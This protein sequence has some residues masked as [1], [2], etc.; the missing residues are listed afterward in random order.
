MAVDIDFNMKGAEAVASKAN[1]LARSMG[2]LE[3]SWSKYNRAVSKGSI[4][5][6]L[7]S[8]VAKSA[9]GASGAS[10]IGS[11]VAFMTVQKVIEKL[12]GDAMK[13]WAASQVKD[14]MLRWGK[15]LRS[16]SF[17]LDRVV[18]KAVGRIGNFIKSSKLSMMT[19]SR[20]I[21][22]SF[23]IGY[24]AL[25]QSIALSGVGRLGI[26]AARFG[27]GVDR[28]AYGALGTTV[29]RQIRTL[30]NA[31]KYILKTLPF[32]T[33]IG[34]MLAGAMLDERFSAMVSKFVNTVVDGISN[35]I[36]KA[37]GWLGQ[38]WSGFKMGLARFTN[39][40]YYAGSQV[41]K[42]MALRQYTPEQQ[43]NY[44]KSEEKRL[45]SEDLEEFVRRTR[46]ELIE[47]YQKENEKR[48]QQIQNVQDIMI[49]QGRL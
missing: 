24:S 17:G 49:Q 27:K 16:I 44:I 1:N 31:A 29:S 23:K 46:K 18:G 36:S 9:G 37:V 7:F 38:M 10:L 11:A 48:N 15:T 30:A 32:R 12:T 35:G 22:E 41:N 40:A 39:N 28:L 5:G 33:L 21:A 20:E 14:E 3:S 42:E 34:A 13:N 43:K 6:G 2:A 25:K 19:F 4:G 47:L 26:K 45:E 8:K